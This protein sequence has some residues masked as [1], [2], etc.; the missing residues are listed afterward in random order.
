M[1]VSIKKWQEEHRKNI[2]KTTKK[3]APSGTKKAIKNK[4]NANER[5]RNNYI[6]T[7]TMM[8][9]VDCDCGSS[10]QLQNRSHHTRQKSIKTG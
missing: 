7:E 6:K 10:F 8:S 2:T 3:S 4:D 5:G 9:I 1:L